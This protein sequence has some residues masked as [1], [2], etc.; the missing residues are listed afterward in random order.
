M[1][2]LQ[3]YRWSATRLL[4]FL[5]FLVGPLTILLDVAGDI[6]FH[7]VPEKQGLSIKT[8]TRRRFLTALELARPGGDLVVFAHSQGSVIAAEGVEELMANGS[9]RPPGAIRLVTAGSPIQTLYETFLGCAIARSLRQGSP[10]QWVN[11][12]RWGDPIG[13]D[14]SGTM[15]RDLGDGGHTDFW[16]DRKVASIL[17]AAATRP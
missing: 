15:N 9:G 2:A 8:E 17:H 12:T 4:P 16:S 1:D 14:I 7:L 5:P 11:L 13:G 3:I 6:V 10:V